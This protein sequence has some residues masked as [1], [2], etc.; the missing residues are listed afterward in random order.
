MVGT[1]LALG[2]VPASTQPKKDH[3][4]G[5]HKHSHPTAQ[6][7]GVLEDV[8]EYHVE[9]V[10]KD[11]TVALHVRDHDAKDAA[12]EGFKATVL[13]TAGSQRVGPI[14]LKSA[15]GNKMEGAVAN[16]PSGATAILTLTD[17]DGGVTQ[18]RFKLK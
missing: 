5:D 17:K 2:S 11:G 6:H 8:G 13:I 7:G 3:S 14:T 4:H 16:V 15:G 18:G 10:I 1:A 9:L 12:T